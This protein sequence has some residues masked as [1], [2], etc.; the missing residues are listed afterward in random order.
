MKLGPE[1]WFLAVFAG[2]VVIIMIWAGK[3]SRIW[4]TIDGFVYFFIVVLAIIGAH[5]MWEETR[6]KGAA[7]ALRKAKKA[8]EKEQEEEGEKFEEL[9]RRRDAGEDIEE[10]LEALTEAI[11]QRSEIRAK[12][13][14]ELALKAEEEERTEQ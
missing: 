7:L 11:F 13:Q 14:I 9:F 4:D 2:L 3:F 5:R 10:E 12:E 6:P 1:G 8:E